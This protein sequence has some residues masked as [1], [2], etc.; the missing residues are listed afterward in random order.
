MNSVEKKI[1]NYDS[2]NGAKQNNFIAMFKCKPVLCIFHSN[3]VFTVLKMYLS[4][5]S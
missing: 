1:K 5:N 4:G 3:M 2:I